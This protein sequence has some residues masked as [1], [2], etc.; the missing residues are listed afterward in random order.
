MELLQ[1]HSKQEKDVLQAEAVQAKEEL[2]KYVY[3]PPSPFICFYIH[4]HGQ[5]IQLKTFIHL[6]Q[7][8]NVFITH[9]ILVSLNNSSTR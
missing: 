6:R 5:S 7:K 8:V 1:L 3:P 4:S 9:I 2:S